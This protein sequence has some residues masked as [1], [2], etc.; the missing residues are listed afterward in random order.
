[1][2]L[3]RLVKRNLPTI[4]AIG[5]SIGVVGTAILSGRAS[6]KASDKIRE[7][8]RDNP[9]LTKTD[10]VKM[11]APSYVLTAV[12]GATTIA[13][14]IGSNQLNRKQI[15]SLIGAYAMLKKSY[16]EYRDKALAMY[17][18]DDP[19]RN[20]IVE[21]H[22]KEA[23]I[24]DYGDDETLLFY[25]KYHGEFFHRK[26]IEVLDAEYQLNRKFVTD[27]E[28]SLNDFFRLLTLPE[29]EDGDTI[30]WSL[31]ACCDFYAFSWIDFE[32]PLIK[33]EDGMECHVLEIVNEPF[34]G[35]EYRVPWDPN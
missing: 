18:E 9:D 26:M 27:G 15:A 1:M 29:I 2:K 33:M 7:A 25:D 3:V 34:A 31:E 10:V 30:G 35:F 5:A 16:E 14:I 13:C 23:D 19:I 4:F 8:K 21:D 20:A 24:S 32:H 12:C 11:A 17:G 22:Y 28:A 6:V